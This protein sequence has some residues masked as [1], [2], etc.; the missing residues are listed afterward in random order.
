MLITLS[1][2]SIWHTIV[3]EWHKINIRM[4]HL[5]KLV[6]FSLWSLNVRKRGLGFYVCRQEVARCRTRDASEGS[7]ACRQHR[8]EMNHPTQRKCHQKSKTGISVTRSIA[9]SSSMVKIAWQI[10]VFIETFLSRNT[11]R[12]VYFI[13]PL[14]NNSALILTII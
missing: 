1:F 7:I 12:N 5:R 14:T 8:K 4:Y 2:V 6:A 3:S 11:F 13:M 10:I 9:N